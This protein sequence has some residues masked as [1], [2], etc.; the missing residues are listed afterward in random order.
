MQTTSATTQQP[1]SPPMGQSA[2]GS[3]AEHLTLLFLIQLIVI[4]SVSRVISWLSTRC[5]GQTPVAGEILAGLVLGPSLLGYF[6]PELLHSI[7]VPQT[8]TAFI[9]T[10]QVGLILLMF[11]VGL[12]FEF[13]AHLKGRKRSIIFI[14]LG[15]LLVPFASG[16]FSAEFFWL[17]I[18]GERPPLLAFQ[19]FFATALSITALPILGRIFMELGLSRSRV[20]TLTIGAAAIDDVCGWLILGGVTSII[21][22]NFNVW[23]S[24]LRMLALALFIVVVLWQVRP[25]ILRWIIGDLERRPLSAH[26]ISLMLI[27]LFASA[28]I[29]NLIGVFSII[30]GFIMGVALHTHRP[31]V[32]QWNAKVG[33]LVNAFFLP[34]FFAYTGLRTDVGSLEGS[35]A[36]LN[37]LLV[38][39]VAFASKFFGAY[40]S[41]RLLGES[42]RNSALIGVCMNT[43]ALMEL[44]VLNVG[45]DL[46]VLP[47]EYFTI[48]VIMAII[49][50]FIASP[51]IRLLTAR[52]R[53]GQP[54]PIAGNQ[55]AQL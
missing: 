54:M 31:F 55:P 16:F 4:F 17:Q 43:R 38:C 30:G 21:A 46:G 3:Q 41:S 49:S 28:V 24:L 37:C 19:L 22:S 18:T 47:K 20:A 42:P 14:S 9:A 1:A 11:Q 39:L 32:A 6:F 26:G 48:L 15:G 5:L 33:G 8:S 36:L 2:V 45:Y 7:F 53:L 27:V 51:L 12:E 25:L 34:V 10:A 23:T 35:N 52:E 29:T 40:G 13:G 50:T 44:V